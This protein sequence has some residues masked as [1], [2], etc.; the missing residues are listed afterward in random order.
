MKIQT[1]NCSCGKALTNEHGF[2]TRFVRIDVRGN[3][4]VKCKSCG[5]FND[6]PLVYS[7]PVE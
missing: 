3:V 1:Q 6:V 7:P 4:Q 2:K 5:T